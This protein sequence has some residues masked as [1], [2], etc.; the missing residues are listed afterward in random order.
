M[1]VKATPSRPRPTCQAA[2]RAASTA[3]TSGS[4]QLPAVA[5]VQTA[6]PTTAAAANCSRDQSTT[7]IHQ[8]P[9]PRASPLG[10]KPRIDPDGIPQMG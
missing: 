2:A 9:S 6:K 3:S 10:I 7:D 8:P 1:V 4:D 5:Q